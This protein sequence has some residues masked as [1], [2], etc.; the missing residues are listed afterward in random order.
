MVVIPEVGPVLSAV[1]ALLS[2]LSTDFETTF[3][4]R[5]ERF[6]VARANDVL[7]GLESRCRTFIDGPGAGSVESTIELSADVRYPSEI[8]QL[9]V[10]LRWQRFSSGGDVETVRED[11]HTIHREI[12]GTSDPD[13]PVM[14]VGWRGRVRCRYGS[15]S[16]VTVAPEAPRTFEGERRVYFASQGMVNAPVRSFEGLA[17]GERLLGPAIVESPVTTIVIDP[18]AIAER[19]PF[20]SLVISPSAMV[21]QP[22]SGFDTRPLAGQLA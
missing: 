12:F 22:A 18:G 17:L 13:S 8:W 14:L 10:P 9:E 16:R 19:R 5:S 2:D 21:G 1:G 15:R 20:G 3:V 6:D 4:T 11:F 7:E